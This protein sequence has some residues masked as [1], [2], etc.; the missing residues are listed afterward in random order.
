MV[1]MAGAPMN[2][3]RV[4]RSATGWICTEVKVRRKR[5]L[6]V[7]EVVVLLAP[8]AWCSC[9]PRHARWSYNAMPRKRPG[10]R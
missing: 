4:V 10:R 3:A 1:S 2:R 5:M 8:G 6:C 7:C 9:L